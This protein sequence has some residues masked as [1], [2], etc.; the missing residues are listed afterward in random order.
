MSKQCSLG[1]H[2]EKCVCKGTRWV[3]ACTACEGSG[4][5]GKMG[6]VCGT[7]SGRGAVM[8]MKPP[9]PEKQ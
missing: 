2:G 4:Y 3:T 7:C 1:R 9:E 5:N 8:A 6:K